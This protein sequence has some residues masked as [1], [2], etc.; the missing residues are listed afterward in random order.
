[1]ISFTNLHLHLILMSGGGI[2]NIVTQL[3]LGLVMVRSISVCKHGT[4]QRTKQRL[5]KGDVAANFVLLRSW[6]DIHGAV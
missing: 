6:Y 4:M 3:I 2:S 1:M 5:R